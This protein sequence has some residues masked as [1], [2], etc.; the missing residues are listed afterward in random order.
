MDPLSSNASVFP[1]I[2]IMP[3]MNKHLLNEWMS[4]L[5]PGFEPLKLGMG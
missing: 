1:G 3:G 5:H 4:E 2:H